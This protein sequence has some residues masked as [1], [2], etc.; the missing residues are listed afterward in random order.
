MGDGIVRELVFNLCDFSEGSKFWTLGARPDGQVIIKPKSSAP[1]FIDR[2]DTIFLE[3]TPR[4]ITD[5][6]PVP[7]YGGKILARKRQSSPPYPAFFQRILN[8]DDTVLEDW[9][10][11]DIFLDFALVD[12][13]ATCRI[14]HVL[15]SCIDVIGVQPSTGKLTHYFI[16]RQNPSSSI[17]VPVNFPPDPESVA[18]N[19]SSTLQM[20]FPNETTLLQCFL[21]LDDDVT[22]TNLT[23]SDLND[24]TE[25]PCV[26]D[27]SFI[28]TLQLDS[29]A[30]LSPNDEEQRD[31]GDSDDDMWE[32]EESDEEADDE[33]AE[34][35]DEPD[36]LDLD[37]SDHQS[38]S[39]GTEDPQ[40]N[41]PQLANQ[42]FYILD[43]KTNSIQRMSRRAGSQ[44][45]NG[46]FFAVN[47]YPVDEDGKRTGAPGRSRF[48]WRCLE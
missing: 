25:A 41:S 46:Y 36:I 37:Q 45:G 20:S 23:F 47:E 38:D 48:F 21:V 5:I 2:F 13:P 31:G 12:L 30:V 33:M 22:S 44:E 7:H 27:G 35:G 1:C 8:R 6:A 18:H 11:G 24:G 32:D 16:P 10:T 28:T 9:D 42:Y 19:P 4:T 17:Q 3:T 26:T 15:P 43:P 34:D 29:W 14:D 40:S 39:S